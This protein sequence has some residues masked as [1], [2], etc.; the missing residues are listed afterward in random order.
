MSEC[1]WHIILRYVRKYLTNYFYAT[2]FS[3]NSSPDLRGTYARVLKMN[4]TACKHADPHIHCLNTTKV[5]MVY[6]VRVNTR[7]CRMHGFRG[8]ASHCAHGVQ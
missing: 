5:T 8:E 7:K 2:T 6:V 1:A 3:S 4:F